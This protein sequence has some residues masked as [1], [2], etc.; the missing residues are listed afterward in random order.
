MK[1]IILVFISFAFLGTFEGFSQVDRRIGA[2]QRYNN[3]RKK[4]AVKKD[5]AEVWADYMK[6]ELKLDDLQYAVFKT[7]FEDHQSRI[8]QIMNSNAKIQEKKDQYKVVTNSITEKVTL[9]LSSEQQKKYQE[10][11]DEQE[12]KMLTN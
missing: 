9:V 12:K 3:P 10:L 1:K 5:P 6:K 2:E 8:D 11:L 7:T 4:N